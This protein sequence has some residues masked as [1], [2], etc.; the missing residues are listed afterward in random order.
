[1]IT[2][3]TTTL[4]VLLLVAIFM[5]GCARQ[6]S[7]RV[8]AQAADDPIYVPPPQ[9]APFAKQ[10]RFVGFSIVAP[11]GEGWQ[12]MPSVG[13]RL[14][15]GFDALFVKPLG[16]QQVVHAYVVAHRVLTHA[17]DPAQILNEEVE[18]AI[19]PRGTL[20]KAVPESLSGAGCVR[21]EITR[22]GDEPFHGAAEGDAGTARV[23]RHHGYLCSHPDAPA[24]LIEIGYFDTRPAGNA[25]PS[26]EEGEAFLR[27]ISFTPLAAH[28]HQSDAGARP[29]GLVVWA[30]ALW[31]SREDSGTVV[32]ID[33]ES[34]ATVAE[35]SVGA[36]PEGLTAGLGSIWVPNW[37]SG[38]VSRIDPETSRVVAAIPVGKGPTDAAVGFGSV[39]ITNERSASVSRIDPATNRV[40]ATIGVAG[41]PVAL[42]T[43]AGAVW[44]ENF[45]TDEIWRIDPLN[46]DVVA[47]V[48]VGHG[49]HLIVA[50]ARAVWVSNSASNTVSKINPATNRV[51]ATIAVGRVPAGLA[52]VGPDVW[53]ANFGDGTVSRI[54]R[55]SDAVA[56]SP[57]PVGDNPFLLADSARTIWV[58]DVW[59]WRDG[60]LSRIDF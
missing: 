45:K 14:L 6:S 33:P 15:F 58:L 42:A 25:E 23:S 35:V 1:M 49:R 38:T 13:A 19:R 55:D 39:W 22:E 31:I 7:Q 48:H 9:P 5:A 8:A 27:G 41:R 53:V 16:P 54:D 36:K 29:R 46:N 32:K 40:I 11:G 20:L 47:T 18:R 3:P 52:L 56:G 24:Y 12:A 59:G 44:V 51:S 50:D 34:A 60:T 21:W 17:T 43:G 26:S 30:N 10:L 37:G 28:V 57:I 4:S 2:R